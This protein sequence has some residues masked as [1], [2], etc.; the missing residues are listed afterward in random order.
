MT[1]EKEETIRNEKLLVSVLAVFK[2]TVIGPILKS[3]KSVF[4]P[5]PK[6]RSPPKSRSDLGAAP[7]L[8]LRRGV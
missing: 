8:L 4:G 5:L 6:S 1:R 7:D 3:Q 2:K